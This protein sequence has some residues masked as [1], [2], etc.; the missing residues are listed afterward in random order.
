MLANVWY[1]SMA[2]LRARY[3]SCQV[4]AGTVEYYNKAQ[5]EFAAVR[6]QLDSSSKEQKRQAE[7]LADVNEAVQKSGAQLEGI[8]LQN[9]DLVSLLARAERSNEAMGRSMVALQF[10]LASVAQ[11]DVVDRDQA[12][13]LMDEAMRQQHACLPSS[14]G[15][16]LL[17][18]ACAC[19][20]S[21]MPFAE[22]VW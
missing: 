8:G 17:L 3:R 11:G 7:V 1:V 18:C 9:S 22:V 21:C 14:Q 12:M 19:F 6:S 2:C 20:A 4:R 5:A 15:A 16:L 10:F 13:R